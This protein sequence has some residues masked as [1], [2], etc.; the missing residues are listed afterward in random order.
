M[1]VVGCNYYNAEWT[2]SFQVE[3]WFIEMSTKKRFFGLSSLVFA[4]P[5]PTT[6]TP[7]GLPTTQDYE[8]RRSSSND[9]APAVLHSREERELLRTQRRETLLSWWYRRRM[10]PGEQWLIIERSIQS[11]LR[12]NIQFQ[13]GW[14]VWCLRKSQIHVHIRFHEL[15]LA[16]SFGRKGQRKDSV[17][18]QVSA[19]GVVQFSNSPTSPSHLES[20]LMLPISL[21]VGL[22]WQ[23]RTSRTR[24]QAARSTSSRSPALKCTRTLC[25]P[26]N[27]ALR[28]LHTSRPGM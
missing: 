15:I 8:E 6:T 28:H 25:E 26:L 27:H 12:N 10:E 5:P 17:Y 7:S 4:L 23:A 2:L 9:W 1:R 21:R 22:H 24:K 3:F 20:G 16:N 19:V 13:G 18:H 14:C 11:L